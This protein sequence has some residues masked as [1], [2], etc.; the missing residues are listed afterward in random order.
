[1]P[2]SRSG[3]RAARHSRWARIFHIPRAQTVSNRSRRRSIPRSAPGCPREEA[4]K[5]STCSGCSQP[6]GQDASGSETVLPARS[7]VASSR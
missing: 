4:C 5:G 1:M 7:P 2:D 6:C 3:L